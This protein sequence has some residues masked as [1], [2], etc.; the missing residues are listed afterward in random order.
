MSESFINAALSG[1][2]TTVQSLV[3]N[4]ENVNGKDNDGCTALYSAAYGGYEDVV[5]F[6]VSR[7]DVDVNLANVRTK[8]HNHLVSLSWFL[9]YPKNIKPPLSLSLPLK[10]LSMLSVTTRSPYLIL[11][12]FSLVL[13]AIR[14]NAIH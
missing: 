8:D 13:V 14:V 12:V 7:K 2:L 3:D 10:S 1:D 4:E 5:K 11:F 9:I 6:L